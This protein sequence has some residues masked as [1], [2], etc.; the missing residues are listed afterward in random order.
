MAEKEVL[1]GTSSPDMSEK[2]MS[3]NDP[4]TKTVDPMREES[5]MTRNGLNLES[6]KRRT[7]TTSNGR[8]S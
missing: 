1:G 8:F 3:D 7:F 6:F 5:F 2:H 4:L